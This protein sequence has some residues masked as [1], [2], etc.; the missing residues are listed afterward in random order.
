MI[1]S[2]LRSLMRAL[3]AALWAAFHADDLTMLR[4]AL[5][6]ESREQN[7]RGTQT[8][9]AWFAKYMLDRYLSSLPIE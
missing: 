6:T 9:S 2:L 4:H 3:L 5:L 1:R 7:S 8:H